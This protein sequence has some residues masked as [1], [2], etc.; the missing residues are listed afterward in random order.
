[1]TELKPCPF[2][3]CSAEIMEMPNGGLRMLYWVECRGCFTKSQT[4]F[5]NASA[6][7][8]AWNRRVKE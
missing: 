3:G 6:S 1:M 4:S 8:T 5:D 2:C 7:I